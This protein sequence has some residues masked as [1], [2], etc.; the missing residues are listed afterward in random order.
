[1]ATWRSVIPLSEVPAQ[2]VKGV[3]VAGE[4]LLI[5]RMHGRL[6]AWRDRCP[7]AGAPLR[8]GRLCGEELQ[9]ARH[10]WLFNV[11]TGC[12]IPD[13]PAFHLSAVPVKVEGAD[14]FVEV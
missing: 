6:F 9:C 11:A 4:S 12:S 5:G 7:H 13:D 14:V 1:M 8:T 10:G 3:E 2:G